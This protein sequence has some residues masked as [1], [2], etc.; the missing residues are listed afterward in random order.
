ML[1]LKLQNFGHLRRRADSLEKILMLGKNE[2]ERE[3][4]QQMMRWL[5]SI[6]SS[7]EV[8]LRKLREMAGTEEPGVLRSMASQSPTGLSD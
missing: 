1:K 2:S 8:Y 3:R 6:T 7:M 5:D 4:R